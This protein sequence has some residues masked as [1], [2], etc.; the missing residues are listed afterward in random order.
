MAAD[1]GFLAKMSDRQTLHTVMNAAICPLVQVNVPEKCL[2]LI[3]D[4]VLKMMEE[5]RM[6]KLEKMIL[7]L[8]NAA[9][10]KHKP[11]NGPTHI[12]AA[13]VWLKLKWKFFNTGT[14]KEAC[15]LFEV[16]AKQLSKV[17]SG[18]KYLGGMQKKMARDHGTK[19]KSTNSK[20]GTKK[21]DNDD[22]DDRDDHVGATKKIKSCSN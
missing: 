13:A 9:C 6:E 10:I 2:N 11:K 14:A 12:L 7:P 5:Q 20:K 15:E 3:I 18:K 22:G 16:H 1:F 19:R 8:H 17:I 21:Q 4:P